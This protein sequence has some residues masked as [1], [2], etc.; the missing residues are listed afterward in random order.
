MLGDTSLIGW[1]QFSNTIGGTTTSEFQDELGILSPVN[2]GDTSPGNARDLLQNFSLEQILPGGRVRFQVGKLTTRTF[3]NLNRYAVGDR[4]DYFSPLIVNNPVVL[5]T[6]RVG[7]GTFAQYTADD[8]YLIGM[9][10]DASADP[11]SRFFD[12]DSLGDGDWEYAGEFALT[13]KFDGLGQG[14]YRATYHYT[15]STDSQPSD[16]DLS[17]S[18]DQDLG[19]R[20]AGLFRYAYSDK[21]LRTFQQRAVVGLRWKKPFGFLYDQFGIAGWWADPSDGDLGDEY[22]LEAFWTLQ[23]SPF[24][25]VAPDAQLIFN[26]AGKADDTPVSVFGV[27][28]R[29]LL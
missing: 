6:A 10:R 9:V 20:F 2:G 12:T 13:P 17:F 24:F 14:N 15:D 22:G 11:S 3:L 16:W 5:Y 8:W 23:L 7:L 25:E 19:E 1:Y 18:F 29:V 27:R 26:R 28:A 21:G 4:E